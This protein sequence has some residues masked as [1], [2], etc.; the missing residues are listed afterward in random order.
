M[1]PF[2]FIYLFLLQVPH[3]GFH[4]CA[5]MS[6]AY[7]D[8]GGQGVAFS[9]DSFTGHQAL[10]RRA[11]Y[12][13]LAYADDLLGQLLDILDETGVTVRV[14]HGARH[15]ESFNEHPS[16]LMCSVAP[17]RLQHG[18]AGRGGLL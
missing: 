2:D 10:M 17:R 4:D 15:V 11:Y 13:C 1:F 12:G 8:S 7:F 18:S 14:T 6:H 16:S 9:N 3:I 5:E